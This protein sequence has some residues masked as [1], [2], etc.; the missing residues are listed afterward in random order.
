METIVLL[1][2]SGGGSLMAAYQ[3]Q[4]VDP[5]V[6]PLAGMRPAAGLTDL[7][8]ADGYVAS[9]AHPGRPDVLTKWMDAAVVDENDPVATG[10]FSSTTAASIQEVSTSGRPR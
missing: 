3:A 10:S 7:L 9:A 6:T 2:N 1:G 5:N 8:P 4:A